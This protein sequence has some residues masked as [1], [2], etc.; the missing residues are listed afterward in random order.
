[1]AGGLAGCSCLVQEMIVLIVTPPQH[2]ICHRCLSSIPMAA[3]RATSMRA[4]G[5]RTVWATSPQAS[6]R[7]SAS[8]WASSHLASHLLPP[9]CAQA[10]LG[11]HSPL[12]MT[13][14]TL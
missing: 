11:H 14:Y 9:P 8:G 7:W 12:P 3:G 6:W 13:P 5:A 1:M 4:R 10:S 2:P